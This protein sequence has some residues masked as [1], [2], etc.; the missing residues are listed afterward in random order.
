MAV[1]SISMPD[2]L[3]DEL[4]AFIEDHGY[5]GRSEAVREGTRGLIAE[6][7]EQEFDGQEVI[8]VITTM[9]DHDPE[10]QTA[11]SELRHA[12]EDLV[13][14][15]VHS[16]AG[17]NCLELFVVEATIDDISTYVSHLRGV[18]GV[19]TVEYSVVTGDLSGLP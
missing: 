3:L 11:L 13:T 8:C 18:D 10:T 6:F 14:S 12:N 2:S 19:T 16:H 4:D 7:D 9:F 5:S 17:S 15:N 1:V